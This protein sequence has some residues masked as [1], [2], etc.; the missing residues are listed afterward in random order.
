MESVE[1]GAGPTARTLLLVK[2]RRPDLHT[3]L[4]VTTDQRVYT[5]DLSSTGP[6]GAYQ[7]MVEWTY[8][9]GDLVLL[10]GQ[11]A[12]EQ[13]R[14]RAAAAATVAAV[15]DLGHLH[16][17]YLILKQRGCPLPPWAPLRAFDDGRKTYVQF[18]PQVAVTEAPPLFVLGRHGDAQLV[19]YRVKGEWY[20]V[21]RLFDRAELRLGDVPQV[22]VG[23]RRAD[24]KQ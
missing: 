19:N 20:V 6:G 16:F 7:T 9:F 10:R 4:L 5:L 21:D 22:V 1:A 3:N 17:D 11:A 24:V 15:P 23:I 13:Q 12:E 2:P 8:P 14:A 18:P